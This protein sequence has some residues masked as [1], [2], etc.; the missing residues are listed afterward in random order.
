MDLSKRNADFIEK[1]Q[2]DLNE[3]EDALRFNLKNVVRHFL[4]KLCIEN[5]NNPKYKKGDKKAYMA[6][7]LDKI[8]DAVINT[9]RYTDREDGENYPIWDESSVKKEIERVMEVLRNANVTLKGY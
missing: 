7:D 6:G 2:D 3:H 4:W 1:L 9:S 8:I 5:D